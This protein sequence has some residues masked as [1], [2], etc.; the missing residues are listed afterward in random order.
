MNPARAVADAVLFE[1]YALYPYRRSSRKNVSRWQ[2]GVL[3][4]RAFSEIDGGDPSFLE[5]QLL[6]E[7]EGDP[8]VCGTLRFL[9]LRR[10]RVYAARG[11]GEAM[12]PVDSVEIHGRLLLTWDEG[13]VHEAPFDCPAGGVKESAIELSPEVEEETFASDGAGATARVEHV[14][15]RLCGRVRV[16]AERLALSRPCSRVTIRVEN[17]TPWRSGGSRDDAMGLSMLGAHLMLEATEGRILSLI[18]PPEWAVAAA[19]ECRNVRVFPVLVGDASKQNLALA[20]PIILYDFP[21]IAPESPADL[22]DAT[23]IDE[24]LTLRTRAMTEDEKRE[25][26]ATDP[27]IASLIDRVDATSDEALAR[28][29]GAFRDPG[30]DRPLPRSGDRVRLRPGPRR[31]DAQD[32]FL[33]GMVATVRS[34]KRDVEGRL[35]LA[36]TVDDDPAADLHVEHGRFHYFYADEVEPVEAVTST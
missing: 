11:P 15:H 35:C 30:G 19:K 26:R 24:I 20:S 29:H 22:F 14:R 7:S 8:G 36:V 10:R 17:D 13:V 32:M 34:V 16:S 28:M 25:A 18:D 21:G 9:R 6:V 4:P 31:T 12:V 3:A 5:A 2:F 23:E 33:D 1:G 27:R